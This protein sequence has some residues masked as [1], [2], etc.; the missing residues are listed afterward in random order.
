MYLRGSSGID[1]QWTARGNRPHSPTGYRLHTRAA[2]G[3]D[4]GQ[5]GNARA[6]C[7]KTKPRPGKAKP[8]LEAALYTTPT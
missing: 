3:Y 4:I 7:A 1:Q 8:S 6:Q 2:H 5:R